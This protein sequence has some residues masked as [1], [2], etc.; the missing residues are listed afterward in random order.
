M[1]FSEFEEHLLG[2]SLIF[3]IQLNHTDITKK[4]V[5]LYGQCF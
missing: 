5:S 3:V 4:R 1:N 2:S